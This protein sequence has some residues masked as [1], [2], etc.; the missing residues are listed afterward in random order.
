M[1]GRTVTVWRLWFTLSLSTRLT[2]TRLLGSRVPGIATA[3]YNPDWDCHLAPLA[4]LSF[5]GKEQ[6]PDGA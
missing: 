5:R 2:M 1:G 6:N 4:S 3:L